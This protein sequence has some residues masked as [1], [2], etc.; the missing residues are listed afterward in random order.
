MRSGV[1]TP[2]S[3]PSKLQ[4]R[5]F[6]LTCFFFSAS[7]G[8]GSRK[9]D[10][11][12]SGTLAFF[13]LGIASR[14]V[15]NAFTRICQKS[16]EIVATPWPAGPWEVMRIRIICVENKKYRDTR[17]L[18]RPAKQHKA[19]TRSAAHEPIAQSWVMGSWAIGRL[20]HRTVP[21]VF[22]LPSQQAA[23][24]LGRSE[25]TLRRWAREGR[26]S[27]RKTA[28]SQTAGPKGSWVFSRE[29]VVGLAL[30]LRG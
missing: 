16:R 5:P 17:H 1:R 11:E 12:P 3:P 4:V 23:R 14:D 22:L 20:S 7:L 26:I 15:A 30:G 19:F 13:V 24:A 25:K 9:S 27:A 18:I 21:L 10:N 2:L 8:T 28:P 6:G 29:D